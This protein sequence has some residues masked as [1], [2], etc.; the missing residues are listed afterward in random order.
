MTESVER[1]LQRYG[2][3]DPEFDF[4]GCVSGMCA[5]MQ[6]GLNGEDSSYPMIPTYLKTTDSIPENRYAVV[7][8]AGGTNFRC[9]LAHFENGRCII[10]QVK[11][12]KMPGIERPATWDQFISFVA[13]EI[14]DLVPLTDLIGFCFS[15]SAEITPEIDGRV[16]CIDKEV[17]ILGCEGKL[18]G[19]S[20]SEELA[21]RGFPGKHVI[22]LND[23]AAVQLGG[24]AKHLSDGYSACFGQVS[25]TGSNTCCTVRGDQ[26]HKLSGKP[27]DMIVNLECGSYDG[28][29]GGLFDQDLDRNTH[30]PGTKHFEK[31]TAGVYLGELCHRALCKAGEDGLLTPGCTRVLASLP[32]LESSVM[33]DWAAGNGLAEV[34]ESENDVIVI[35]ELAQFL[36]RRSA[37]L[38]CANLVAMTELTDAGMHGEKA[39]IFAEGSLVQ[40]NHFYAPELKRLLQTHLREKRG[41]DV[42]LVIEDGT[43]L[44]G[45][46]AAVLLNAD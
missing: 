14:E 11:K 24:F 39:A 42:T 9:G 36:F 29:H 8:D 41:R 1:F 44:P 34:A 15:Y 19:K 45:A 46:A 7:I 35:S 3:L 10:E 12:T 17:N 18:V 37:L 31:M 13:D 6:R 26:I 2:M 25:G 4:D 28:L 5:D 33:D 43:T 16:I 20:L 32:H 27:F 22:I 21:C 40:R 38:M 23:T 30:S